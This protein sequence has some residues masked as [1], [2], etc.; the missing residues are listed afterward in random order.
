MPTPVQPHSPEALLVSAVMPCLNEEKTLGL[1]IQKVQRAFAE[2]GISGEV[3]V[4]DNGS[5]DRSVE[6]AQAAQG[7]WLGFA[8][9]HLGCARPHRHHG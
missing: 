8:G 1:C 9:R 4:A 7:L 6:I 2:L 3:V 5:A